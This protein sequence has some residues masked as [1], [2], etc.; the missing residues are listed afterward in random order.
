LDE[1]RA[2]LSERLAAE[3]VELKLVR[4]G[5]ISTD[6]LQDLDGGTLRRLALGGGRW[7]LLECPFAPANIEIH[8]ADLQRRGF[9]VL[10]AHPERSATFQ[11]DPARLGALVQRGALGQ[12]T[13]SAFAGD[14]GSTA[15]RTA[16]R[17]LEEGW[18]HVLAS[19]AHDATGRPP[20]LTLATRALEERYGDVGEQLEWM[21]ETVPAALLS[22]ARLR[23][24]PALPRVGLL[25]RIRAW[26]PR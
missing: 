21:T 7:L 11:R 15:T 20:D 3:G 6:R 12:V 13:A 17:M 2:A 22:G 8:V 16:Q 25:K 4:G 10:L 26:S 18:V 14:F 24:R 1:A 19:D 9:G 5:E 23:E